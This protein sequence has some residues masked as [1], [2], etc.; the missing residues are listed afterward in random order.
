MPVRFATKDD[1][2]TMARISSE[3][4]WDDELFGEVIHPYRDQHPDGPRLYWLALIRK[5]WQDPANTFLVSTTGDEKN[6]VAAWAQWTRKGRKETA[7]DEDS[8][9]KQVEWP[10][11]PP[12]EA[13]HPERITYLERSY[14]HI[15]H[16]WTGA[17]E[18]AYDIAILA[19]LPSHQ[20]EGH[21]KALMQWGIQRATSE[22]VPISVISALGKDGFYN[23]L[24]FTIPAGNAQDGEGNPLAGLV[25]GGN[26][27]W[28]EDHLK[29]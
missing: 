11:L 17:R 14:D 7:A 27:W 12:N 19:T 25:E 5:G 21:G 10:A 22:Q 8:M 26:I 2:G 1:V 28:K 16:Q 20:G 24:G 6:K 9:R 15:S 23:K 29:A 13:A 18:Q 4:F 3:A